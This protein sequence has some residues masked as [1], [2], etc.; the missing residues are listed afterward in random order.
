MKKTTLLLLILFMATPLAFAGDS[1]KS[2]KELAE[3]QKQLNHGYSLLYQASKGFQ[4]LNT[5]VALKKENQSV[6]DYV[7]DLTGT[8]EKIQAQLDEYKK[9]YPNLNFEDTG[10]PWVMEIKSKDQKDDRVSEFFPIFGKTGDEFE[11]SLMLFVSF[12][13][14]ELKYIVQALVDLEKNESLNQFNRETFNQLLRLE[15][16]S[17]KLLNQRYFKK[18]YYKPQTED[19]KEIKN[20]ADDQ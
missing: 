4:K 16:G 11:R 7:K 8:M 13:L 3:E 10:K 15:D 2:K 14:N 19:K 9:T 6:H 12:S 1:K 18:N 5:L 20:K 17:L